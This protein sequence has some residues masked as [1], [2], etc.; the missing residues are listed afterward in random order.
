[1]RHYQRFLLSA[2]M[3]V[4]A[5]AAHAQ[6]ARFSDGV[7]RIGVL[8]DQSGPYADLAGEGSVVA[9]RMAAE[10]FGNKIHGVPIEIVSA[11]H[12]NKPDVGAAIAR[13]WYDADGVDVIVDITNSAVSS[14]VNNLVKDRKKLVL[15]NSASADLTGKGCEAHAAQWQYTTYV[16]TANVVNK[17][18]IGHG[19]DKFFILAV[20]YALGQALATGFRGA[21]ERAGGTI[22]GEVHHPLNT[23]D[24]SSFLLQAQ[25]SGAKAVMLADAGAD[26]TTA[27]RQARDFGLTPK[28][29]LLAGSLTNEVVQSVGLDTIQGMES[30]V[31]YDIYRSKES[32]A[33]ATK[34]AARHD[35]KLP[36][37]VHASTYSSVFNYLK[38]VETA[39]TDDAD[40][41]IAELK[42]MKINDEF[43]ANGHV[44]DDGAMVHDV[45]LVRLKAPKESAG[46]GDWYSVLKVIPG[47]EAYSPLSQS[48]CPLVR[49]P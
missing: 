31:W 19:T 43:A 45:Y 3:T 29:Q 34:F 46:A 30:V 23:T 17:D 41:V 36:T 12:Q 44:R 35:G 11:D 49:K 21:V 38:A 27:I 20:D 32:K 47:D 33:W 6:N 9:A 22:V 39:D 4:V 8:N 24:F 28:M 5:T 40:S 42:T 25:A 15:H 26:L 14:A 10:E 13:K 37:E 48:E 7:I 2:T 1:M 16:P 18:T